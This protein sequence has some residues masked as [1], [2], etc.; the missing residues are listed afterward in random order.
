MDAGIG[1]QVGL[2]FGQVHIGGCIKSEG[3]SDGGHKVTCQPVQV[4][5]VWVLNLSYVWVVHDNVQKPELSI[6]D[7]VDGVI[8]D[9]EGT[10]RVLRGSVGAEDGVGGLDHSCRNLGPG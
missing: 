9:R 1:S 2:G 6:A 5:I 7:V 10:I 4:S 3:R 8:V